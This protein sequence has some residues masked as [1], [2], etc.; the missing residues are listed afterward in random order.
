[1]SDA[2]SAERRIMGMEHARLAA[3][4]IDALGPRAAAIFRAH[5]IEEVPQR[6]LAEQFGVSLSTVES[7]LRKAYAALAALKERIDEA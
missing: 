6:R 1:M 7:D 4:A 2:P 3:E 5:R